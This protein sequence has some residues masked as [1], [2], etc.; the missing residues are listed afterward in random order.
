MAFTER[1]RR[2]LVRELQAIR[3]VVK[4]RD[5]RHTRMRQSLKEIAGRA[6]AKAERQAICLALRATQ[7]NKSEASRL[8][9][10]DYKT[11]H[12]KMKHYGIE[13]RQFRTS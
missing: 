5:V 13:A 12:L 6:A 11:L 10:V 3:T 8:L 1:E 7:G 9:Q 2:S 4:P